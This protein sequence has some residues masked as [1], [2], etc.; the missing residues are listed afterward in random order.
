MASH[1]HTLAP[2]TR[3]TRKD[4]GLVGL[5]RVS[6]AEVATGHHI[7]Q[8]VH[9]ICSGGQGAELVVSVK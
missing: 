7:G 1:L 9:Q 5:K 3:V 6:I 4:D 8:I 2:E